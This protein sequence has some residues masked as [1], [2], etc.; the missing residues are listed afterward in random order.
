M[1]IFLCKMGIHW[2]F[3]F[4]IKTLDNRQVKLLKF[5]AT[6]DKL[7]ALTIPSQGFNMSGL[8]H[9]EILYYC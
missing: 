9:S 8:L 4:A 5:T 3:R 2:Y 1:I 7:A 6:L